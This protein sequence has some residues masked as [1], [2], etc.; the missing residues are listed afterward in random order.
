[1]EKGIIKATEYLAEEKDNIPLPSEEELSSNLEIV[2]VSDVTFP[3]KSKSLNLIKSIDGVSKA[4]LSKFENNTATYAVRYTGS[5]DDL[6]T[7]IDKNYKEQFE[8][9][10]VKS[11]EIDM[12]MK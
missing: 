10:G 6:A 2:T 1:M 3:Q 4:E 9:T 12:K 7:L 8:I 5:T 11:G